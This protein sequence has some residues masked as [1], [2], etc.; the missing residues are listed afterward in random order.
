VALAEFL[1]C[2]WVLAE[3]GKHIHGL[4][5]KPN[6]YQTWIDTYASEEFDESVRGVIAATDRAAEGGSAATV[7]RMHAAFT[8]AMRLEWMFWDSAYRLGAWPM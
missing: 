2:F 4:A 1:R 6:P 7:D 3:V 8:D 5:A